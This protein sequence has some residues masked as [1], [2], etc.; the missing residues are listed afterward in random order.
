MET[1]DFHFSIQPL[2]GSNGDRDGLNH[3]A[4]FNYFWF[5]CNNSCYW[6]WGFFYDRDNA[7]GRD[8]EYNGYHFLTSYFR[9]LWLG[10]NLILDG[11]YYY[12]DYDNVDSVG[13]KER[14]DREYTW[15]VSLDKEFG[16]NLN[17]SLQYLGREHDSNIDYYQYDRSIF[18]LTVTALF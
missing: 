16:D 13:Q 14:S 17:V 1:K 7:K 18:S 15:S 2:P 6:R 8:W 11:E 4:G 9:P 12:Q 10:A 3:L 5:H